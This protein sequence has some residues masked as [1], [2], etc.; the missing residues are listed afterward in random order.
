MH[1]QAESILLDSKAEQWYIYRIWWNFAFT[2]VFIITPILLIVNEEKDL[3]LDQRMLFL[4]TTIAWG[5]LMIASFVIHK[6]ISKF[7]LKV[8][9]LAKTQNQY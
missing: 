2:L 8:N 4:P 3:Q 5:L 9:E 1:F 6:K 7:H